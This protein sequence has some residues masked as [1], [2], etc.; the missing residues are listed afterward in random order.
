MEELNIKEHNFKEAKN[1]IKKFSEDSDEIVRFDTVQEKNWVF[2]HNVTG[3]ELNKFILQVQNK[4]YEGNKTQ[5]EIIKEFGQVYKALESLDKDYINSIILTMKSVETDQKQIKKLYKVQE[6]TVN[7][8][9][10]NVEEIKLVDNKIQNVDSKT[11]N[12]GFIIFAT[13]ISIVSL[14]N[15]VLIILMLIHII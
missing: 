2:A 6:E 3:E 7:K 10:K 14:A 11:N 9:K 4:F 5:I 8:L 15:L 1:A 13:L 12:S